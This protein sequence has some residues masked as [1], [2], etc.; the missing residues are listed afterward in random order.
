MFGFCGFKNLHFL[1][2]SL[3]FMEWNIFLAHGMKS[4]YVF[5]NGWKETK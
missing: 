5:K 1:T 2:K 3:L 4:M